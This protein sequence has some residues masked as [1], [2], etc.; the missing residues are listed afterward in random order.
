MKWF[1][2]KNAAASAMHLLISDLFIELC[3]RKSC[4]TRYTRRP[5]SPI[6][7]RKLE[8]SLDRAACIRNNFAM[9]KRKPQTIAM[10]ILIPLLAGVPGLV[11][12]MSE[13]RFDTIRTVDVVQ[14]LGSGMCFGVALTAIFA[15][16]LNK[17]EG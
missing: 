8:K 2:L 3:P 14:L 6:S 4:I 12:L 13:P 7:N 5:R 10:V 9:L 11:H 16:L 1:S 17:R 15:L